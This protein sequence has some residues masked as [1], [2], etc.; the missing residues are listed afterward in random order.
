MPVVG[1][2]VESAVAPLYVEGLADESA[3]DFFSSVTLPLDEPQSKITQPAV[4]DAAEG[5]I[6]AREQDYALSRGDDAGEYTVPVEYSEPEPVSDEQHPIAVPH[7]PAH[8][9]AEYER[10]LA[11]HERK[12]ERPKRVEEHPLTRMQTPI[13]F[14]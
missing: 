9:A 3:D 6:D 1:V 2:N 5:G 13:I 14:Q 8:E 4:A 12:R 7:D 11:E 10:F